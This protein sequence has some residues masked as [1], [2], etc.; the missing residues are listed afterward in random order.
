MT[1]THNAVTPV[2]ELLQHDLTVALGSDNIHD[3]YKPYSTGDMRTELKFLLEATHVYDQPTLI[4]IA[5][6][7]GLEV[8]GVNDRVASRNVSEG[9]G[10][11]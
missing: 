10:K 6:D 1:P 5:R 9:A 7:N 4:K 11:H 8:I 2:D 3:V